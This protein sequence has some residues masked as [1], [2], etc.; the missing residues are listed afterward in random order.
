MAKNESGGTPTP[1]GHRP[2]IGGGDRGGGR[3]AGQKS[4]S[5]SPFARHGGPS[6]CCFDPVEHTADDTASTPPIRCNGRRERTE[7]PFWY[8]CLDACRRGGGTPTACG[9]IFRLL[10]PPSLS[11]RRDGW[12]GTGRGGHVCSPLF[13]VVQPHVLCLAPPLGLLHEANAIEGM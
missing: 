6:P 13:P 4:A 7:C 1:H 11:R 2:H 8:R 12:G 5:C 3:P 9:T 10:L